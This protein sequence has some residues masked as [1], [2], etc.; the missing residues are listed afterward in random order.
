MVGF[1]PKE[2]LPIPGL[3]KPESLH[4]LVIIT[5]RS[6]SI[7]RVLEVQINE[8]LQIGT[9]DLV[10][11]DE[12]DLLEVHGEKNV[13]EENLVAPDDP[14]LLALGPQPRWPLVR[15]EFILEAVLLCEVR[16]EFLE[17]NVN[18]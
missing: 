8:L 18:I 12:D 13:Q 15:D 2:V 17:R 9:N 10:S 7:R 4:R 16:D 6:I 11:V 5:H 1:P 14:L 3:P